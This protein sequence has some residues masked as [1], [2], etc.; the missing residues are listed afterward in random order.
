MRARYAGLMGLMLAV[1]LPLAAQQPP[2]RR[3]PAQP[4]EVAPARPAQTDSV[5][6]Q[7]ARQEQGPSPEAMLR[8]REQLGLTEAQVAR[9]E[10]L[11]QE[12]VAAQRSRMAA[13]LDIQ[14]QVRAGQITPEQARERMQAQA[15]AASQQP[16]GERVRSVLT[17]Q[18]R[19][20]LAEQQV[21]QMRRQLQARQGRGMQRGDRGAMRGGR[22][23]IRPE[24]D[25][26]VAPDRPGIQRGGA[27]LPPQVRERMQQRIR[28]RT[29]QP[30]RAP[31]PP[32]DPA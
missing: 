14:S 25:R 22:G 12:T 20:R 11:R 27:A 23:A 17:D 15:P 2:A 28:E 19:L 21:E 13:T 16:V 8:M 6:R 3:A 31:R 1:A 9:L 7:R 26:R 30:P 29:T 24:T 32:R 5:R 4:R 18:Q 10:A